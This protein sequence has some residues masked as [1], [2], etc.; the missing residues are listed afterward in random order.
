MCWAPM[1]VWYIPVMIAARLG[2][3][4]GAVVNACVYRTDSRASRSSTGVRAM[5]SP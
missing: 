2:A 1:A 5:V 4:T 3:H